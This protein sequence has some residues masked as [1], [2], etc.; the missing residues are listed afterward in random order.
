MKWAQM[1]PIPKTASAA[2]VASA[3]PWI[4]FSGTAF[5]KSG[6]AMPSTAKEYR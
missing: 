4:T 5:A 3:T 6:H 1:R 2:D